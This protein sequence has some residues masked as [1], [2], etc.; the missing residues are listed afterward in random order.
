LFPSCLREPD[1]PESRRAECADFGSAGGQAR[2]VCMPEPPSRRGSDL[3]IRRITDSVLERRTSRRSQEPIGCRW[4]ATG[5]KGFGLSR[6]LRR[7]SGESARSWQDECRSSFPCGL[8]AL[9][10]SFLAFACSAVRCRAARSGMDR[11]RPL[12]PVGLATARHGRDARRDRRISH[13]RDLPAPPGRTGLPRPW[14]RW[15]KGFARPTAGDGTS[16]CS[17]D[18][19][20][21]QRASGYAEPEVVVPVLRRVP[22]AVRRPAVPRG[23][24]PA[25]AAVHA[26]RACSGQ[27]PNCSSVRFLNAAESACFMN[28]KSGSTWRAVWRS[29]QLPLS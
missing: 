23:V 18:A 24:V 14:R 26:V 21:F 8:A 27:S 2:R 13:P 20:A 7:N 1:S 17:V 22:V 28:A 5:T 6:P 9:R 19:S 12:P 15:R 29:S 3:G 4:S 16:S 11:I 25:P 10:E